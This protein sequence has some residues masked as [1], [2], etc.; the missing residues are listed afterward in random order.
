MKT[1]ILIIS[2]LLFTVQTAKSQF[3]DKKSSWIEITTNLFD[4]AYS[5]INTYE[6]DGDTL[7]EGKKYSN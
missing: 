2:I 1:K 3:F 7:I 6:I 4:D 5:K